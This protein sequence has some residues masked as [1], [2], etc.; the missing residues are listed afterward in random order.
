MLSK[1]KNDSPVSQTA[2]ENRALY[3]AIAE[4]KEI[5]I[6]ILLLLLHQGWKS[7]GASHPHCHIHPLR[8]TK[9]VSYIRRKPQKSRRSPH[10]EP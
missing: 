9:K 3:K 1:V 7:V 5:E 8:D 2:R 6:S 10:L 4:E